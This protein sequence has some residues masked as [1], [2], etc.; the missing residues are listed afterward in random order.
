MA[1]SD[2]DSVRMDADDYLTLDAQSDVR[3]EFSQGYVIAMTGASRRHNLICGN[4][5]AMLHQQIV[6]RPCEVYQSDM[7]VQINTAIDRAYRYPDIVVVCETP[8]LTDTTPESLLNPT[9]LIEV[10]SLSTA[11]IDRDPKLSE[12]RQIASVQA[13]I[14]ISRPRPRLECYQR[15]KDETWT[16]TDIVGLQNEVTLPSIECRLRLRDVYHKVSFED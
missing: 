2:S 6:D 5:Y 13:Y 4:A 7:R 11:I 15:Q 3:H 16:Y 10:L 14:L 1:L 12:Y 8:R 9:V